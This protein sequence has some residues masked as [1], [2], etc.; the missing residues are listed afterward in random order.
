MQSARKEI[1][2]IY[3]KLKEYKLNPTPN[4]EQII[5]SDFDTCAQKVTGYEALDIAV[6]SF[7]ENKSD[8]LKVLNKPYLPLHNNLR[9]KK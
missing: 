6:N 4:M 8:L 1:W 7:K 9:I 3:Q 5:N 2:E